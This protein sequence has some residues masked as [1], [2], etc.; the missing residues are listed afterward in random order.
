MAKVKNI[1]M[2]PGTIPPYMKLS[3]YD[4]GRVI[5]FSMKD[6]AADYTVPS[7]ATVTLEGTKPSGLGFTIPCTVVGSV[8]AAAT[9]AEMTDEHGAVVA[10]LVVRQGDTRIGSSNVRFDIERSPHPEGTTDGSAEVII[11]IFTQLVMRVEA[12]VAKE[13]VL[14]EAEA[15]AVGQ[16][17]GE[18]VDEGDDTYHNNAKYYAGAAE[19]SKIAA[20][21]AETNAANQA[22][23]ASG[24]AAAAAASE[25]DAENAATRAEAAAEVAGNVFAQV[26]NVTL[27][28]MEDGGV[29]EV[30]TKED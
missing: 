6:D 29:R 18:D 26:G 1:N 11:P 2:M 7:G 15:W 23:N 16:R 14:H 20:R 17:A 27:T 28:V 4:V 12:A 10:E 5:N 3:Q 8:A 19:A 13:E 24:S 25:S 22:L 30:W 9:T 21:T